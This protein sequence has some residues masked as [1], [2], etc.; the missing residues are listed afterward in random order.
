MKVKSSNTA[1]ILLLTGLSLLVFLLIV[2]GN[3][4]LSEAQEENL[5]I[6]EK[7]KPVVLQKTTL[8]FIEISLSEKNYN[9]LKKYRD[10]ALSVGVISTKDK[11]YVPATIT[12]N[13]KDYKANI[14]LK[15]DWTD[16]LVGDKWSF[17]IKLKGDKTILGMRK[18]SIH[19][20]KTRGYIN[21]WVF[22][23]T[24]KEE[25]LIGLRYGFAE[26]ALHIEKEDG[27][28]YIN[29][30]LGVYAIEETFDKRMLENNKRKESVILKF[31]EENWWA[32]VKKRTEAGSQSGLR[33]DKFW[34]NGRGPW[35]FPTTVFSESKVLEDTLMAN[36]FKLSK[37]L[38]NKFKDNQ[39]SISEVFNVKQ[40]AMHNALS[41]LFGAQH[42]GLIINIRFY[43]NP[44]TSKLEPIT[45]DGNSGQELT[46]FHHFLFAKNERDQI[47]F[48][49]LIKALEIVSEKSYLNKIIRKNRKE[50]NYFEVILEREFERD[51]INLQ[52]K[53]LRHNQEII[54]KE[55]DSLKKRFPK[56]EELTIED[57]A[58]LEK[59]DVTKWKYT[60]STLTPTNKEF[61][62]RVVFNLS[63]NNISEISYVIT[64]YINV[65]LKEDYTASFLVKA[66]E[67]K[68][69]FAIRIQGE[70]PNRVDAVFDLKKGDIKDT[71]KS[72]DFNEGRARIKKLQEGWYLCSL[73]TTPNSNLF[74]VIIGSANNKAEVPYWESK[75]KESNYIYI[76]L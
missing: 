58:S 46:E 1:T 37:N 29:N 23:K 65:D 71:Q 74:K 47:Y 38:I 63:N 62:E 35:K 18:F 25:G 54:K 67:K 26:G 17:R 44:I 13:G 49:E 2:F 69:L 55:L 14:R 70:Y 68:G 24:S 59:N 31:S 48:Q 56:L 8:N 36:Y 45:F 73:K 11:K 64:N 72:G 5:N 76:A 28:G 40:L 75:S 6:K 33:W 66:S 51:K 27:S 16:H 50:T 43:Y 19:H 21:E 3:A 9:K 42:G 10:R 61:R 30:N 60:N 53:T 57:E 41:N 7:E 52:R 4:P 32:D 34:S 15:G 20:P 22:Q 12:F 39:Y